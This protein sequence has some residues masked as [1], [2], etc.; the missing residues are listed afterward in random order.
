LKDNI[1]NLSQWRVSD[2]ADFP[3]PFQYARP[4]YITMDRSHLVAVHLLAIFMFK[5][6]FKRHA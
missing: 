5:A 2:D 4:I 6:R 3:P 1:V